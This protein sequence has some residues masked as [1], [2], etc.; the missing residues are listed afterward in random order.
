MVQK[1][2]LE[3]WTPSV[4]HGGT[5]HSAIIIVLFAIGHSKLGEAKEEV[6]VQKKTL[7]LS[8]SAKRQSVNWDNTVHV[9]AGAPHNGCPAPTCTNGSMRSGTQR[10]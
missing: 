10:V 7:S 4:S 9:E 6:V 2:S 8:V 3:Q 5:Y 1:S